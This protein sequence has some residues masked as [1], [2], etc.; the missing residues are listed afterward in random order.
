MHVLGQKL[1]KLVLIV[2]TCAN[3]GG[4][5]IILYGGEGHELIDGAEGQPPNV[6]TL[7]VASLTWHQRSTSCSTPDGSPGVRSLHMATVSTRTL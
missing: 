7:D 2:S 5:Q 1:N 4:K 6:Y 3:A